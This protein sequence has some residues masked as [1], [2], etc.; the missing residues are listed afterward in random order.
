MNKVSEFMRVVASLF[1]TWGDW[2]GCR[3]S[4]LETIHRGVN[5]D[6]HSGNPPPPLF[7]PG[8]LS[9]I[10]GFSIIL[11]RRRFFRPFLPPTSF[12]PPPTWST[13]NRGVH[14]SM[15]KFESGFLKKHI[16]FPGCILFPESK[17]VRVE[18]F[19]PGK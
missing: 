9:I 15:G 10:E 4:T 18:H 19:D 13:S 17:Y 12:H 1:L 16:I 2:C 7:H 6:Y 8:A 3:K 5:P 14:I 11:A